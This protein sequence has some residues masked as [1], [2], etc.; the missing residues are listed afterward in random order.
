[1]VRITVLWVV[2]TTFLFLG[3]GGVAGAYSQYSIDK[4][5][6]NCRLCHGDF[7][8]A[9]YTSLADGGSWPD[10]LH[11]THRSVML[12]GDC[13]TCHS[14][15][16]RFPV[17][18]GSSAGGEGL[19][20]ISCSG[21]H[22]RAEDGTG[23]GS[24]GFG[25]GLRQHHWRSGIQT[26]G[27]TGCHTDDADPSLY[28]PV[29]EDFL[30][31]YYSESDPAHPLIPGDPCNLEAEG[32]LEDYAGTTIGLDNDGNDLYDELDLIPCPEPSSLTLLSSGVGLLLL[33]GRRRAP[34]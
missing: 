20:P 13:S 27:S 17:L 26:C 29:A 31:P 22:G 8:A 34:R 6:T 32:F 4:D 14:A 30:P 1:M 3:M 11:I 21:C 9:T 2:G 23:T 5:A 10:G 18:L 15:G 33:L 7:D 25:A 28:T 24:E 16:P 19:D 12:N